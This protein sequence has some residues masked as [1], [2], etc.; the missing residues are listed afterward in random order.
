MA[1]ISC[2]GRGLAVFPLAAMCLA[3]PAGT[4]ALADDWPGFRGLERQNCAS[5]PAPLHWSPSQSVRW[6]TPLPGEGHSSPIVVGDA[7]YLS[8]AEERPQPAHALM[9]VRVG[10]LLLAWAV[11]ATA[12]WTVARRCRDPLTVRGLWSLAG[13]TGLAG[14]MALLVVY[15][16]NALTFERA[17]ERGWMTAVL[18]LVLA[19]VLVSSAGA[20]A[21]MELPSRRSLWVALALMALSGIAYL[22]IPDRAHAFDHGPL[23]PK[24]LF[25]S[26]VVVLPLFVGLVLGA[27]GLRGAHRRAA[28]TLGL[29]GL[30]LM[31]VGVGVLALAVIRAQHNTRGVVSTAAPYVPHLKWWLPVGLLALTAVGLTLRRRWP[32]ALLVNLLSVLTLTAFVLVGLGFG[33]ERLIVRVPYLTYVIGQPYYHPFVAPWIALIFAGATV[34]ALAAATIGAKVRPAAASLHALPALLAVLL[35]AGCFTYILYV[36]RDRIFA[37]GILCLDRDS[38]AIRWQTVGLSGPK[39]VMHSDNSA[40]TPT[41]VSDGARIVAY[42][43]TPGLMAVDRQ[44]ALL[45]TYSQLPFTSTEG[46]A[47]SPIAWRDE[48]IVLSESQ[49]GQWLV[50]LDGE[51]GRLRWRTARRQK[52]HPNAG[53][54]RTPLVWPVQGRPT[55][56]VWG[57]EDLS[58]YDPETGTELW[59]HEVTGFGSSTNPVACVV[60][61]DERFYLAGPT[62][63]VAVALDRVGRPGSP[64]VWTKPCWD[65]AQCASPVL[66]RGLL[67]SVSDTGTVYCLEA[68]TGRTLWEQSFPQQHYASLLAVSDRIY[69]TDT[70][71]KT[72]VVACAPQHRLLATNDLG[73]PVSASVA[74]VEGRLHVRTTKALYCL[75]EQ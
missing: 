42:F 4:A 57:L 38:G 26:S 53:N 21:S 33:L 27:L 16:E 1:A 49:A 55:I 24:S 36:P 28:W 51:T 29:P 73:E 64:I 69:F 50:A 60:A 13:M 10:L 56:I 39:G 63:T 22:A 46:V 14:A 30:L 31:V 72:R 12:L 7:V 75:Q 17:L 70:A 71:G 47:G 18:S 8:Y 68:A 41:P 54:C 65:G 25:L 15:G 48:I 45:W 3:W 40:A 58:G 61:D 59:S 52:M 5:G 32:R 2:S 66:S 19:L 37:R 9:A 43:G 74:P 6:R 67:F 35:G 34:L 62:Q 11:L 20:A 44:G 23:H